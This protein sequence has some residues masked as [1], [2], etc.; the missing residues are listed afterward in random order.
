MTGN[1]GYMLAHFFALS[2]FLL[3]R[4]DRPRWPRPIRLHR[5]WIFVAGILAAANGL[6]IA[7]GAT[8]PSLTGYGGLKEALIGLG[9]LATSIVLYGFRRMAQD[10]ESIQLREKT[11]AEPTCA[12]PGAPPDS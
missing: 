11:P 3:L 12:A 2:G 1:L 5:A 10:K 8:S 7:V 9:V 4:R 6:V